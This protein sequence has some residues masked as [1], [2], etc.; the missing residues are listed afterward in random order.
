MIGSGEVPS[1]GAEGLG[2]G[3]GEEPSA[4]MIGSGEVPS[5]GEEGSVILGHSKSHDGPIAIV[6]NK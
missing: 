4:T 5:G 3:S 2:G 1:G 6:L